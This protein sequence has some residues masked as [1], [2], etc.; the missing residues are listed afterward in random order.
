VTR[1]RGVPRVAARRERVR[2][3]RGD[4]VQPRRGKLGAPRE[5]LHHHLEVRPGARLDPFHA[6]DRQCEPV[7]EPVAAD[8]HRNGEGNEDIEPHAADE[9]ADPDKQWVRPAIRS[10]VRVLAAKRCALIVIV[11]VSFPTCRAAARLPGW[12]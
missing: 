10:H 5:V 6:A 1:D 8:V 2:L 4:R 9:R 11:E 12:I 3:L 7:G